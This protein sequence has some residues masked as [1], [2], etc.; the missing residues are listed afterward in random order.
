MFRMLIDPELLHHPAA[1]VDEHRLGPL[2]PLEL[3]LVDPLDAGLAHDV[4]AAEIRMEAARA[5]L[6]L[7]DLSHIAE[8]VGRAPALRIGAPGGDRDGKLRPLHPPRLDGD[9][10]RHGDVLLDDHRF[11]GRAGARRLQPL[12]DRLRCQLQDPRQ[13]LHHEIS[14]PQEFPIEQ[15][16]EGKAV[17]DQDLPVAIADVAPVGRHL[18]GPHDVVGGQVPVALPFQHLVVPE[19]EQVAHEGH[20]EGGSHSPRAALRA[21]LLG[22]FQVFLHGLRPHCRQAVRAV[23]RWATRQ[24]TSPRT[25]LPRDRQTR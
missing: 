10:L 12:Q 8:N 4:A 23:R 13:E 15:H 14:V 9:R 21:G 20:G 22:V 3:Q 5:H 2:E 19:R 17:L 25:E 11:V 1:G 24:I 7:G 16:V 18:L 6:R